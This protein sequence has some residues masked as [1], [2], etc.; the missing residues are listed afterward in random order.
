MILFDQSTDNVWNFFS[1]CGK[2]KFDLNLACKHFKKFKSFELT[3]F[4]FKESWAL[5]HEATTYCL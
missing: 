2:K 1:I 4:M 5:Q 3:V